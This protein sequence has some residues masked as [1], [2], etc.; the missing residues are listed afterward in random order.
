MKN[1]LLLLIFIVTCTAEYE[2]VTFHKELFDSG[3][4]RAKFI[5]VRLQI[6]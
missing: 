4:F 2:Y 3:D 6:I 5:K 1:F